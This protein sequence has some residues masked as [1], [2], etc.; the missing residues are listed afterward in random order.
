[1][2]SCT[3]LHART[4]LQCMHAVLTC[5]RRRQ[6]RHAVARKHTHMHATHAR[7]H[8]CM[9]ACT[10]THM[11]ATHTK[12][13]LGEDAA[14]QGWL[15]SREGGQRRDDALAR[16]DHLRL[17]FIKLARHQHNLS[18]AA[19]LISQAAARP[20]IAY[21]SCLLQQAQHMPLAAMRRWPSSL[22]APTACCRAVMYFSVICS[23][24]LQC[25]S[26][27]MNELITNIS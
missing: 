10:D 17:R 20:A 3:H 11:H 25:I 24:W 5:T 2:H 7:T 4:H 1:M 12:M 26:V 15:A 22:L 6:C 21:E 9:H 19:R 23:L 14:C 8:T 13:L 18:L 27:I 16:L